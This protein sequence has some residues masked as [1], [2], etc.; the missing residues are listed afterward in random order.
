M[1]VDF[2]PVRQDKPPPVCDKCKRIA[3]VV[4]Q[5]TCCGA[6]FCTACKDQDAQSQ[7]IM[8]RTCP[9]CSKTLG[10]ICYDFNETQKRRQ[11]EVYC[12]NKREGCPYKDE[13]GRMEGHLK[14]SCLYEKI[15]CKHDRCNQ[16]VIRCKLQHHQDTCPHR[17]VQC[18]YC[19]APLRASHYENWHLLNGCQDFPKDCKNKCGQKVTEREFPTHRLTCP[20][21]RVPCVFAQHGCSAI[22]QR[23]HMSQHLTDYKHM[24]LLIKEIVSLRSSHSDMQRT[25]CSLQERLLKSNESERSLR[26]EIQTI[27]NNYSRMVLEDIGKLKQSQKDLQAQVHCNHQQLTNQANVMERNF[28]FH[29]K[30]FENFIE[31]YKMMQDEITQAKI[32]PP[33]KFI[34]NNVEELAEKENSHWS[35]YFYSQ[36][37]RHKLRLAIFP[38]GKGEAK[39]NFMSVWL[40]RISNYG[41]TRMPDRVKIQVTIELVS[42]LPHAI[43]TDNHVVNIDAVVNQNQQG[44]LIFEDNE[45]I[46]NGELDHCERRRKFSFVRHAQYKLDNSLVFLVRSAAEGIL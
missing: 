42:Q 11:F 9:R 46:P 44:G 38:A 5:S 2:E 4:Y 13:I 32:I 23:N 37:R 12:R 25:I 6:Y 3:Y 7:P 30:A 20:C 34:I 1:E 39:G 27:K 22:V 31:D 43:E 18:Q 41:V 35:P 26:I 14:T 19:K 36:C 21:E 15:E 45:F 33:F 16:K 24:E 8:H 29:K 10:D 40:Y 28:Q 17:K